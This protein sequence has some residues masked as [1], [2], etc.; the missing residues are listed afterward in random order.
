MK[1][2]LR[3]MLCFTLSYCLIFKFKCLLV[4]DQLSL[5]IYSEKKK[6]FEKH[7]SLLPSRLTARTCPL[8]ILSCHTAKKP[9]WPIVSKLTHFIFVFSWQ[10]THHIYTHS[11]AALSTLNVLQPS[12]PGLSVSGTGPSSR[13]EVLDRDTSPHA[14]PHPITRQ[15]VFSLVSPCI[16][17]ILGPSY[18]SHV[19]FVTLYWLI[20][21]SITFQ[22]SPV[23]QD[24]SDFHSVL[25]LNNIPLYVYD[26]LRLFIHLLVGT[27]VVS[28]FWP[29]G[30][31]LLR[32]LVY[33]VSVQEPAFSSLGVYLGRALLCH[34]VTVFHSRRNC[35]TV[36]HSRCTGVPA[37]SPA[38][39]ISFFF[40]S[41]T[42]MTTWM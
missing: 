9:C 33:E 31:M 22:R 29:L 4:I 3:W 14:P 1:T 38:L 13:T 19:V 18:K 42:L 30:T 32:T 21:R 39:A 40:S 24:M 7:E 17:A 34:T 10:S 35:P 27:W 36:P 5:R 2:V 37:F 15:P 28:T 41:A 6:W 25:W 16:R 20:S 26:T 12:P 8:K 23:I 11:S